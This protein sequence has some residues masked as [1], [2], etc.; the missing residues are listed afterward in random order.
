MPLTA[1]HVRI[2]GPK[3]GNDTIGEGSVDSSADSGQAACRKPEGDCA[4]DNLVQQLLI[5]QLISLTVCTDERLHAP[6]K[7]IN[8]K[9]ARYFI[10]LNE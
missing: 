7:S 1:Y 3:S 2:S 10:Y 6:R 5:W 4:E 9:E 8:N